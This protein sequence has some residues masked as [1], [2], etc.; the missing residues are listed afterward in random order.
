MCVCVCVCVCVRVC[1]A[2]PYI[3]AHFEEHQE[4]QVRLKLLELVRTV[5]DI[6]SYHRGMHST[7]VLNA[8]HKL[9]RSFSS[10]S[11]AHTRT[12]THTHTHTHLAHVHTHTHTGA[13]SHMQHNSISTTNYCQSG[14]CQA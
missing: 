10:E 5:K 9:S 6:L 2:D 1:T 11:Y 7:S 8:I 3:L 14:G 13:Y 12:H 4:Q